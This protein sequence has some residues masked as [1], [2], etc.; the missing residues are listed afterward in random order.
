MKKTICS[1]LL[2]ALIL[3]ACTPSQ[4]VLHSWVNPDAFHKGPFTSVLVMAIVQDR[5]TKFAVENQLV[6]LF[7]SRGKKAVRSSDLFPVTFSGNQQLTN[8]EM[9]NIIHQAGCDA[10]VTVTLLDVQTEKSYQPRTAYIPVR[11]GHPGS[12]HGFYSYYS[13]RW[14]MVYQPGYFTVNRTFFLETNFYD[15]ATDTLLWSIQ[16]DAF[17]HSS[18]ESWF[19]GYSKLIINQLIKEGLIEK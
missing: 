3:S 10:I 7:N 11:V 13:Y 15:V 1:M 16:S 19:R 4:Q 14:L 6:R 5:A 17:N 12:F 18:I 2:L 8:E 9:A